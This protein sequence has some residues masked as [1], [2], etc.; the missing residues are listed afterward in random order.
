MLIKL[1]YIDGVKDFLARFAERLEGL[2][3]LDRDDHQTT[4]GLPRVLFFCVGHEEGLVFASSQPR[5]H[6]CPKLKSIFQTLHDGR[7]D[8]VSL[9]E[10]KSKDQARKESKDFQPFNHRKEPARAFRVLIESGSLVFEECDRCPKCFNIHEYLCTDNEGSG[11]G[12]PPGS[13]AEDVCHT[14]C[15]RL[16]LVAVNM[17]PRHSFF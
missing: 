7:M 5:Y 16:P 12:F 15:K 9:D 10:I 8:E 6:T 17:D 4:T 2:Q 13:C 14:Y 1:G 3:T 11:D